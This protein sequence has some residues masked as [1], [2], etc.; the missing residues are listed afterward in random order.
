MTDE[1][2]EIYRQKGLTAVLNPCSNAKLA[3]GIP[4]LSRFLKADVKLAIGTDGAASNNEMN[5]FR[6][7]Y[8]ANVLSKLYD[9]E[10]ASGDP[11]KVLDAAI[12]GGARAMRL[13]DC[14]DIAIGKKADMI[15]IDMMRP[16][17]Q[18]VHNIVKNLVYSG[19]PSDVKLTM[20]GGKV[21]Y[22]NGEFFLPD[23]VD[24]VY[25]EVEKY[26]KQIVYQ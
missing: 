16:N 18:P 21:L 26:S 5:M 14:D 20:I 10:A 17:M 9:R 8:L 25:R 6:E 19:N 11:A 1:D 12:A 15:V 7:M 23:S 4:Q 3:S 24:S 2:I 22:E 13:F